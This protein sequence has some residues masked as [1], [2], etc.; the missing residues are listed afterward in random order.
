MAPPPEPHRDP[1]RLHGG[2][3]GVAVVAI[4]S[5]RRTSPVCRGSRGDSHRPR[6]SSASG[7]C[8]SSA[9]ASAATSTRSA[10]TRRRLA[11]PASTLPWMRTGGLRAL[12]RDRRVRRHPAR[13]VLLRTVQHQRR[14]I[15]GQLIL[16]SVAAAVIGGTSLFGGRGKPIH[17][18]LGGLADRRHRVRRIAAARSG[19]C[20]RRWSTSSRAACCCSR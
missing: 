20:P 14:P 3:R 19:R 10:A 1:H 18:L 8:S 9:P 16:Y 4:C 2:C 6:S 5:S 11:A 12:L 13:L 7:R 15:P 17:G